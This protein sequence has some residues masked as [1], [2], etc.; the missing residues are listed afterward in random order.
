MKWRFPT[1]VCVALFAFLFGL[2]I[3]TGDTHAVEDHVFTFDS[4]TNLN[5]VSR[6]LCDSGT[7]VWRPCSDYKYII[8]D[9]SGTAT[10]SNQMQ[11]GWGGT[12][13]YLYPYMY[14]SIIFDISSTT[15]II[16]LYKQS[17]SNIG[18]LT[19]TVTLTN[20]L[21]HITP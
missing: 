21:P 19:V 13:F 7:Y 14:D 5:N 8:F 6:F 12:Y 18:S 1:F 10:S 11:L 2:F 16:F 9:F 4:S 3:T 17:N 20:S 15:D